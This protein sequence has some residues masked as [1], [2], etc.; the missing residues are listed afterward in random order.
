[1]ADDQCAVKS[2]GCDEGQSSEPMPEVSLGRV[3]GENCNRVIEN[4]MNN[5]IQSCPTGE[6]TR[7]TDRDRAMA[8]GTACLAA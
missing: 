8:S 4:P 2:G 5:K 7:Q 3:G 6:R 1:M